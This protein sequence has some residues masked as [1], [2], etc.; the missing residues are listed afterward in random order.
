MTDPE[1]VERA[2]GYPWKGIGQWRTWAEDVQP[3]EPEDDDDE[4]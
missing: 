2:T 1:G 3:G 4:R